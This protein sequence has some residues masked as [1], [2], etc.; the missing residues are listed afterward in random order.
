LD[1]RYNVA[2]REMIA[3]GTKP[4]PVTA[5]AKV[6]APGEKPLPPTIGELRLLDGRVHLDDLGIGIPGIECRLETA[7]RE[8]ALES[9]GGVG[10]QELQ[11]IELSQIALP[12]PLDPFATVL[13]LDTVFIRFTLAGI[14]KR[15]IEEI[16][17]VRPTLAIGP[18][19]FWYIDRVQ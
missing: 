19:L 4:Q 1:F 11:T 14:W 6:A 12:S 2:F 18:D 13:D 15:Q 3:S 8:L 16:A 9:G 10:G 5:G 7:F 17:I